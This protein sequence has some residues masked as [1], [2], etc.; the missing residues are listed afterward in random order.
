MGQSVSALQ[1]LLER[2]R[3]TQEAGKAAAGEATP[4]TPKPKPAPRGASP[5]ADGLKRAAYVPN[6]PKSQAELDESK[7]MAEAEMRLRA[8]KRAE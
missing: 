7:R 6:K 5:A 4:P 2:Q 1:A 3:K 8:R